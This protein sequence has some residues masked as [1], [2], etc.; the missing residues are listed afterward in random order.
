MSTI[1]T[2]R[3]SLRSPTYI[4]VQAYLDHSIHFRQQTGAQQEKVGNTYLYT[5]FL[6]IKYLEYDFCICGYAAASKTISIFCLE[7]GLNN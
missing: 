2:A 6:Y 1:I 7:V 5:L 4:F 3:S